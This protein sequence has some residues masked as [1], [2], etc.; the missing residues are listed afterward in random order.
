MAE[1]TQVREAMIVAGGAGRRLWPLTR[2]T[3]KPLVE[4]CGAPFL[5]GVVRRLAAVG[6]ERVLLVV[7]ASTS[8]FAAL[9]AEAERLG[10]RIEAVAE[11]EP[12]DTAGGVRSA[13]DRVSGPFFV[14][15]G[16]ILTDLDLAALAAAHRESGAVA[17]LALTR[18]DDPSSFGVCITQG[19]RITSF[20]EKPSP[21]EA[22]G[23]DTVNAGTYVLEPA[24]LASFDSGPLSFERDVFPGLL[25]AGHH[26]G[27][28]VSPAPWAD[29][30]TP[31]RFLAGQRLVLDGEVVWPTTAGLARHS[32]GVL[33]G[34]AVE[35]A[36][37]ARLVGPCL[38]GD[39]AHVGAGAT[40]G[41]Y[42]VIG[43]D[44]RVGVG[45]VVRQAALGSG[46]HVGDSSHLEEAIVGPRAYL[47]T[48]TRLGG[49]ALVAADE[50]LAAGT[51]L[52]AGEHVPAGSRG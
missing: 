18:V 38:L 4:F 24:V 28:Y 15:N 36:G 1:V 16:D 27:A 50:R 31:R 20:V 44:A 21:G 48:D 47:G 34:E 45:A 33:V 9:D 19:S 6:V 13:L 52:V 43:A 8:P 17:T 42:A 41:P 29:L 49:F 25:S 7:G 12:L 32:R 40:V 23:H 22:G 37:S 51:T 30:G 3:P 10:V 5:V 2:D 14:L 39:G 26:L 35:V 11:P 46:V